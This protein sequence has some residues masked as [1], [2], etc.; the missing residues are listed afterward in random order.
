MAR[1]R[2]DWPVT[3][4]RGNATLIVKQVRAEIRDDCEYH[5]GEAITEK[6]LEQAESAIRV[7][8]WKY[9]VT[10]PRI[11]PASHTPF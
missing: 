7:P 5:L 3:L 6:L 1:P 9:F 8:N 2:P 11:D 4:Q 10:P